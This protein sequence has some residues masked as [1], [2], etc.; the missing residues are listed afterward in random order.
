[1]YDFVESSISGC[2]VRGTGYGLRVARWQAQG[3]E[4]SVKLKAERLKEITRTL[5]WRIAVL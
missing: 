5:G 1:M 2:E 4:Q 3:L